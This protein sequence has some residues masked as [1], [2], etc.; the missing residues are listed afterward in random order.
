[1]SF[2]ANPVPPISARGRTMKAARTHHWGSPDIIVLESIEV[3]DP[4]ER[5]I[6]VRVHA[7][8]VGPW[9]ALVRSG[10]SGLRQTLPLT[11]RHDQTKRDPHRCR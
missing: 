2:S 4:G 5:E 3:A 9:D 6:L 8:G 7:A 10:N 11:C 1:M